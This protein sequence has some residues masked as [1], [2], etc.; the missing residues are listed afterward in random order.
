MGRL[1]LAAAAVL[2][3]ADGFVTQ[4][5][6][7]IRAHVKSSDGGEAEG[8][9]GAAAEL[10]ID[11][12]SSGTSWRFEWVEPAPTASAWDGRD[13]VTG[14]TAFVT[15]H[16]FATLASAAKPRIGE[17]KPAGLDTLR[18]AFAKGGQKD[19][20]LLDAIAQA[21]TQGTKRFLKR[22]QELT[23]AERED[24]RANFDRIDKDGSGYLD[25]NEIR[26]ALLEMN[27]IAVPSLRDCQARL[28][29][30]DSDGN[31][32]LDFDEFCLMMASARGTSRRG[33]LSWVKS[34]LTSES[35]GP[36]APKKPPTYRLSKKERDDARVNFGRIDA[37]GSGTLDV[38]EVHQAL[39]AMDYIVS[40][41]DC[42]MRLQEF[43]VDGNGELDFDEFCLMMA[44]TKGGA[45][46]ES[47]GK[48]SWAKSLLLGDSSRSTKSAVERDATSRPSRVRSVPS[49]KSVPSKPST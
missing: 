44:S 38:G 15:C 20:A 36:V 18:W 6:R 39:I 9:E 47:K 5:R 26:L 29:L 33:K 45:S 49:V 1:V 28:R 22:H 23:A 7:A 48:A 35:A 40:L 19:A 32:E 14:A 31:G 41:Q 43:D 21:R 42:K 46:L 34:L 13:V 11:F 3:C 16:L 25:V 2:L 27:D 4:R 12:G 37:D 30:F 24:A 10:P 17:F 8:A